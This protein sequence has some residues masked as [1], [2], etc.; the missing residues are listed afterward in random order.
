MREVEAEPFQTLLTA[1]F[2]PAPSESLM[3]TEEEPLQLMPMTSRSPEAT[4]P[5]KVQVSELPEPAT[6]LCAWTNAIFAEDTGVKVAVTEAA[7]DKVTVQALVPLHAPLHPLKVEPLAGFAVSTTFVPEAKTAEHLL[8]QLM[9][10]G[11]LVTVPLPEPALL[12][13]RVGLVVAGLKEASS[14]T[15]LVFPPRPKV[16]P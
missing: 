10:A 13:V 12:T 9:P 7:E 11:T 16:A 3:L 8:P 14:A 2:Q 4:L 5:G 6:Q 15:Q 1:C